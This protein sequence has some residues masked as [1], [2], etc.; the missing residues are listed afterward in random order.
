MTGLFSA[1]R[2]GVPHLPKRIASRLLRMAVS[3]LMAGAVAAGGAQ[4]TL[5]WQDNSDNELGFRIE[6]SAAG[7]S[8]MMIGATG[9]DVT[10]YVDSS[11]EDGKSYTYRVCAYNAAGASAYSATAS[12]TTPSASNAAP[13][14]SAISSIAINANSSSAPIAFTIGDA[15][16][17]AGSLSVSATS[18]NT[19]LVP[20]SGIVHGGSG[21]NRTV[22]VSPSANQTGTATITLAV[23]DGV[24]TS[25]RAFT[26]TVNSVNTA[27]TIS[28]IANR[29]IDS[30]V[31]TGA[32]SFIVGD[33]QTVAGNLVVTASSSNQMLV[34]D[35]NIVLGGSGANRT[36]SVQPAANRSGVA[37]ITV[38]VSDGVLVANESFVLTVNLPNTP[39][40]IGDISNLTIASGSNTGVIRF[41]IGDAQTSASLL[42]VTASSTNPTLVPASA[43]I[44]G[45]GDSSR[46]LVVQP[47]AGLSGVAT[48]TVTVS[49]GQSTASDSFVLT[50]TAPNTAPTISSIAN[51]TIDAN[52]ATPALAF[53]VGDAQTP[54]SN[55][56]VSAYST[57]LALVPVANIA[58]GGS[59]ASRTVSVVPAANQFG[60]AGITVTVSD[61]ALSASRSFVVTVN[62]VNTPP[63]ISAIAS[64]TIEAN[65]STG[66]LSFVIGDAQTAATSLTV[67]ASSSN[68]ALVSSGSLLLS[69]TGAN[70]SITVT[71]TVNQ[72]GSSTIAVEVGDGSLTSTMT[73]TVTVTA[74]ATAPTIT[75]IANVAVDM[76]GS[77][78]AI[79]FTI[80][81]ASTPAASL[82]V[83][84]S[85][86]DPTLLPVGGI[87]LG[88]AGES[89]TVTVT[90][91][92]QRTGS[93]TVT[94]VVSDGTLS[95]SESFLVT[96]NAVNTPPTISAIGDRAISVNRTT[97][98]IAFTVGDSMT[99][100]DSLLVTAASSNAT[101]LPA[102]GISFGGAGANRTII[103]TPAADKSG[104]ATVTVTVSDGSLTSS[105]SFNV[106]V[107][108][109]NA[110]P[111]IGS[112]ANQ[113]VGRGGST[114][115]LAV[116]VN[117]SDTPVDSLVLTANSSNLSLLPQ[118][119]VVLGGSGGARSVSLT[120]SPGMTGTSTVTLTVSDGSS[121]ASTSFV[122][123]VAGENLSPSITPIDNLAL[124][125]GKSSGLIPFS[126]GDVETLPGL[127]LVTASSSNASLIPNV[128]IELSGEGS[129]RSVRIFPATGLTG[130]AAITLTVS[131]GAASASTS[132]VVSVV[133]SSEA[134]T[135][136]NVADRT[137]P[138]GAASGPI[139]FVIG[140]PTVSPELL[141]VFVNSSN[142]FLAPL[143]GIALDGSGAQ[144]SL[145]VTPAAGAT[146]STTITISVSNGTKVTST[147]FALTVQ[148][149]NTT[150]TI[151]SVENQAIERDAS[152]SAIAFVVAD[153]ETTAENLSVTASSSDQSLIDA[154]GFSFSGLGGGRS[155]TITPRPGKTGAATVTLTV[156]DGSLAT[157]T[158]FV[159]TVSPK[160]EAPTISSI[161]SRSVTMATTTAAIEFFVGDALTPAGDLSVTATSSNASLVPN[162]AIVF[163]GSGANR[164]LRATPAAGQT[165]TTTITV[166]VSDGQLSS[167][168][169]FVLAVNVPNTAPTLNGLEDRST[170]VGR[171]SGAIDFTIGDAETP[172]G[173]LT[174]T[175]LSSNQTLLPNQNIVLGGSGERRTITLTPSS[176]QT[177]SVTVTLTVSDGSLV[178][179]GSF[180]LNITAL[181]TAPRISDLVNITAAMN[182][183]VGVTFTVSDAETA[184][185]SLT[186]TATSQNTVLVP[187]SNIVFG[188]GG[189][190]RTAIITPATDR[191][192][193]AVITFRVSDGALSTTASF[194][195]TVKAPGSVPTISRIY[196][197]TIDA[198]TG[199]GSI[200][201]VVTDFDTPTTNVAV[202]AKSSNPALVA[203]GG[204]VL[205]GAGDNRSVSVTPL[206]NQTGNAMITLTASD[207]QNSSSSSFFV[208]VYAVNAAPVLSGL[209]DRTIIANGV[210][211]VIGFTLSDAD[212]AADSL[213]VS[214]SS[215]NQALLPNASVSFS[216][217]GMNRTLTVTPNP[218]QV[219]VTTVTIT[220]SDG[221]LATSK[222]FVLTVNADGTKPPPTSEPGN[223][224]DPGTGGP[225]IQQPGQAD[226]LIIRQ[227]ADA[228][229]EAGKSTALEVTAIAAGAVAY[230][231]Y[232]GARGDTGMPIRGATSAVFTT[233]ELLITSSYWV[234]ISQGSQSAMSRTAVVTVAGGRH[235]YFGT[236][237]LPGPNAGSFAL[238]VNADKTAVFLADSPAL[239][240]GV[241]AR[242]FAIAANGA[243]TF[244]APG[245]G[246]VNGYVNGTSVSGTIGTGL[247]PFSGS[248]EPTDGP[249]SAIAGLYQGALVFSADDEVAALVGTSGRA[250]VAVTRAGVAHGRQGTVAADGVLALTLPDGRDVGFDF[251]GGLLSGTVSDGSRTLEAGGVRDS[252]A[253]ITKV[254][255]MSARAHAGNGAATLAAGFTISGSGTKK[256]LLRATGPALEAFGVAG[257]L[258]DP[259]LTIYRQG[260]G[261]ATV[262]ASNNDW[263]P[264]AAATAQAVG[265]F[266][267]KSG[268][269]DA[270]LV[271]DLPAGG[272]SA[273]VTGANGA[274]GA[275]MVELYDGDAVGT[276]NTRLTNLSLRGLGG[277]GDKV[278]VTGFI[279]SGDAPRR[280]LV[281]AVGPELGAF[282][283]GGSMANPELVIYQTKDGV[284]TE[285]AR[286]DDW[287]AN[288]DV[289]TQV[290]GRVGAFPMTAGSKS[291]AIV[292]WLAPG[293]Y[294][295][296]ARSADGSEGVVIVEVYEAP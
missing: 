266:P 80:S 58:F 121:S 43:L 172:A 241:I 213:V 26:V 13:T 169:S 282:G 245:V 183:N 98:A 104:A 64:R 132:F 205:G 160:N 250:F 273:E 144:R 151:S 30:G 81:H 55:L 126:V 174:V 156:S 287:L 83:S 68:T 260:T 247:L 276:S 138:A 191:T 109:A 96:V 131:D 219:G 59:G 24:N 63:T 11:L 72:V 248:I 140:D 152:S 229:V 18:S 197:R 179:S 193:S 149:P 223:Q 114:G 3:G 57:N 147:S 175:A 215:S 201:F 145:R 146:G 214:G 277:S 61:G 284:T 170:V 27:P 7:G 252:S 139:A 281:R 67:A 112:I 54:A 118:S 133:P 171:T 108:G 244:S 292:I 194:M 240:R 153:G 119:S 186:V 206:P 188:G 161:G 128:G 125:A 173:S 272:Y 224:P 89:R 117:D 182:G 261:A 141:T 42:T 268:S 120:P 99:A 107:Q 86:S 155:V 9:A 122:L 212:S 92:A 48:I 271:M 93:A 56:V 230:Q 69:G 44:L 255:N 190:N 242:G 257:V 176:K 295:A 33:A 184:P 31:N 2:S 259:V 286:N 17:S 23:S 76:N 254:N 79:P 47:P 38:S 296:H 135:I 10:T 52:T 113:T 32:I 162:S 221:N 279:V 256:I 105:T 157:S 60:S 102:S 209:G 78:A 196:N 37:T 195:L 258:A 6:R 202:T 216:G 225:V 210:P 234:S 1:I 143:S 267:L 136:G 246:T 283:V 218:G 22:T 45:G 265:A 91:A 51:A 251:D 111:T 70:R 19:V 50:V 88:G 94:I 185:G 158:Q 115:A 231:W 208:T 123:T 238:R 237:G 289:V 5:T 177:G 285:V 154:G 36:I 21:A 217:E 90:P 290:S 163:G 85:T 35:A 264:D 236:T 168:S 235:S 187:L 15:E 253:S 232:A 142:L 129:S 127:L 66:A 166:T 28:D 159:V 165:G 84:A 110:V 100:A 134:P 75:E 40:T 101:L 227:P 4:L 226:I 25:T 20:N 29:T 189:A 65:T 16:T 204:I 207:G 280:M 164:W 41:T 87:V 294:T 198:N 106:T 243:F 199:T 181:S 73:F 192:G 8:F 270:A 34:P 12:A 74:V 77:T 14:I 288:A 124:V 211:E 167:S 274:T 148:A 203:G 103:V 62:A 293:T 53:T 233:P 178:T 239:S 220:A 46:T 49:D 263:Y 39:P 222:S 269:K 95:A 180:V 82:T 150:P 130:T 249:A 137:I 116:A 262:I 275:T 291:S 97:G 278:I 200:S 228:T 71:P